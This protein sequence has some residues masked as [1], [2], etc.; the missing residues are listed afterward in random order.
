MCRN[1]DERHARYGPAV[2]LDPPIAALVA[3]MGAAPPSVPTS[4]DE[5]RATANATMVLARIPEAGTVVNEYD[6]PVEG[7]AV[8][9]RV[10]RPELVGAKLPGLLFVHGGGWF[11]G[12]LDTAEVECGPMATTVGCVVVSV[13][14][15]LAPEHPFPL[16]LEDCV[17]AWTWLHA[18][19]DELGI[20]P[21]RVAV[22][23]ASAGGNLAASLCLTARDRGLPMPVVQLLDVPCLDLTLGSPSMTE[24]GDGA[25]LTLTEVRQFVE[26]Y[27]GDES[28]A[29]PRIS[30]LLEPDL[31]GLPPAVILVA[32][33][34]PV[35]DDGERWLQ[36]LHDAGVPGTGV[37][38]L[39]QLHGT[40]VV[41][42]SSTWRLMAD[43]R[44]AALR[45]A[46]DGSL[47]P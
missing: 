38:V 23:G 17:A 10:T 28:P 34:D 42:I 8:R 13:A 30:P 2:H 24:I 9:V 6:V 7:G 47:V 31:S 14:Y 20:D 19:A 45:R 27:A 41:P 39:A 12:D 46:F 40:W 33:H 32:E 22:A 21:T 44:A 11:Q 5:R 18:S 26:W 29:H 4:L 35:R 3:A 1:V 43:L 37:R 25:G 16:P 15:R 36:A